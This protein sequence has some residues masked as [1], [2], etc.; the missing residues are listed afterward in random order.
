MMYYIDESV[1][2]SAFGVGFLVGFI[3]FLFLWYY[4]DKVNQFSF[5]RYFS[6]RNDKSKDEIMTT[7]DE[8]CED[9]DSL[10]EHTNT[11]LF[12]REA[13]RFIAFREYLQKYWMS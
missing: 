5:K 1:I 6:M 13:N 8:I 4:F 11:T 9:L 3:L 2:T 12:K 10:A 7:I